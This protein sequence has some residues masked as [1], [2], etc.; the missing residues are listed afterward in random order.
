MTMNSIAVPILACGPGPE[1]FVFL[2]ALAG[3]AA[4]CAG[5]FLW[6][7]ICLCTKMRTLGVCLMTFSLLAAGAALSWLGIIH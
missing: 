1:I 4:I 3:A 6:G 5:C 2:Y 7:I